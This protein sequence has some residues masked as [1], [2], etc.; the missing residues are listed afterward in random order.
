MSIKILS[1][2]FTDEYG[3][4]TTENS[5]MMGSIGDKLTAHLDIEVYWESLATFVSFNSTD[6]TIIRKDNLSWLDLGFK[7]G[8]SFVISGSVANDASFTIAQITDSTITTAEALTT[9]TNQNVNFYGT[10]TIN[11]LDFYYSLIE[12]GS[13]NNFLS[14]VDANT[15]PKFTNDDP[16]AAW[17]ALETLTMTPVTESRGW[18]NDTCTA[19]KTE[20]QTSYNEYRQRFTITHTFMVTPIFLAGQQE[21]FNDPL[22][23]PGYIRNTSLK[24]IFKVDARA[25]LID[26]NILQ[27][28]D[29]DFDFPKGNIGWL[30]EFLSGGVPEYSV[31]GVAYE[32][33]LTG[34][35]L[36][37]L[38]LNRDVKVTVSLFSQNGRF[39]YAGGD[40]TKYQLGIIY[41]PFDDAD[42]IDTLSDE[43]ETNFLYDRKFSTFGAAVSNGEQFGTDLQSLKDILVTS[44]GV[45]NAILTFT[46]SYSTYIKNL[47]KSKDVNNRSYFIWITP[48]QGTRTTLA[49]TDRNLAPIDF[50]NADW[51]RNQPELLEYIDTPQFYKFPDTIANGFTDYKGFIF[52][53]VLS[54]VQFLVEK[55]ALLKDTTIRIQA[56][57]SGTG[58]YFDLE[59]YSLSFLGRYGPQNEVA[60]NTQIRDFKLEWTDPN[61]QAM[62]QRNMAL[63]TVTQFAYELDYG[64]MLRYEVWRTVEGF[65]QA[66]EFTPFEQWSI[67]S[68]TAGWELRYTLDTNV[69][70]SADEYT[71]PFQITANI[72]AKDGTYSCVPIQDCDD[73]VQDCIDYGAV[74]D[75]NGSLTTQCAG[76]TGCYDVTAELATEDVFVTLTF[77]NTTVLVDCCYNLRFTLVT[78]DLGGTIQV[79]AGARVI[80]TIVGPISNEAYNIEVCLQAGEEINM[81]FTGDR[82]DV[83]MEFTC[84]QMFSVQGCDP[85]AVSSIIETQYF[86]GATYDDLAGNILGDNLTH[87]KATF[88]GVLPV[89]SLPDGYTG[90]WGKLY[91]DVAGTGGYTAIEEANTE[92]D[93]IE[94]GLWYTNVTLTQVGTDITLEADIDYTKIP[95]DDQGTKV[96]LLT[97]RLGLKVG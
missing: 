95:N 24:Y 17:I 61:N 10:T 50:Q 30:D 59:T 6:K 44:A 77:T 73:V 75:G 69:A 52:D 14:L 46:V 48:Q 83:E 16:G 93:P 54:K 90:Y 43:F 3:D 94:N 78:L 55:D 65:D 15:A 21:G 35:A 4:G 96:Y 56:Y 58:T 88:S 47:L 81:I 92:T 18:V 63:D 41:A 85:G 62:F 45:N 80:Q 27:S 29:P 19:E 70:D 87:V 71:T 34:E 51:N 5:F 72:E 64:F 53:R 84:A 39:D 76:E 20:A 91:I 13:E 67:Y 32:D 22:T 42:Y 89:A 97:A 8:D 57:N 86:N 9:G 49:T 2:G 33:V 7:K 60:W 12:N 37:K 25:A 66:F 36:N 74:L 1:Q 82:D 79:L 11:A 28:S 31:Q 40:A 26:P 23:A 38:D 68:L